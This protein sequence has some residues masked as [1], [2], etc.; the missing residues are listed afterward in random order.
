[1]TKYLLFIILAL[2]V[3][4]VICVKSCRD[5]RSDRDRLTDNQ[6]TLLSGI[7]F[8]RTRD[9]LSAASVD[10]LTMT[11]REFRE[12]AAEL[13]KT[14]EDLNLKVK[15]LQ[16]ASRTATETEY[17]LKTEV[18]DSIVVLPGRI[19]T[20]RSIDYRDPYLTFSGSIDDREFSGLIQ[21]RDTIIQVVHR[22]PRRF[23]F[24]RWGTKAIRQE[25]VSRNP[26]TRLTYTEYI[27]LKRKK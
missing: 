16:S 18:R 9:S 19:D 7:A 25:M 23:W 1:M 17:R 6:R 20:L 12:Y 27:E 5:I 4:L 24:I 26:Y 2:A 3:S 13:E 11:N 14:V 22:V 8:Y 21:T 15:Y 10:R